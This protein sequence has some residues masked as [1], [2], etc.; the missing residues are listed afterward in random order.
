MAF[1]G[2]SPSRG[3]GGGLTGDRQGEGAPR[4]SWMWMSRVS[5]GNDAQVPKQSTGGSP[6]PDMAG[7][8]AR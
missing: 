6:D 8:G 5:P 7:V 3:R 4:G 2:N 1:E